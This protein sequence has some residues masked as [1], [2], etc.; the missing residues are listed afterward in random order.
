MSRVATLGGVGGFAKSEQIRMRSRADEEQ[1]VAVDLV[2][3]QRIRLDVAIAEVLPIAA[4]R[5]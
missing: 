4:E 1:I 3:Q 5:L 2:D